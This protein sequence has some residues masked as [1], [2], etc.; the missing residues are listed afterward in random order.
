M[1][2]A[3]LNAACRE[4]I[5]FEGRV[6]ECGEDRGKVCIIVRSLYGLKSAG[7][8]FRSALAQVLQDLGY[9]SSKADPDVWLR[10]AIKD[11][12]HKYYEMLFV[13]VDDILAL[14]HR[15]E[16]VINEITTFF[17]AKDGSIRPPEIYL[18]A[19]I[20]KMQLPDGREVWTTSPRTYVKNSILVVER[21]LEEDGE[22]YVLKSNARNPS[23]TGYKPEIDVTDELD[24]TLASRFMQLIGILRWAVEIGRIDI[25]L[26]TSLLSQYQANPRFGHLEAAYHIFAY[27]KK[28]PDMGKLAYDSRTPDIYWR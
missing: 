10:E 15:A 14:S 24:Q 7:A 6:L 3:Y 9:K 11:N 13:Y 26:E 17:K 25:Y 16:D 27:L 5:W 22:G 20:A 12:G 1:E 23:P 19:N 28:H 4:K 8:A 21:L 2:N 18:G